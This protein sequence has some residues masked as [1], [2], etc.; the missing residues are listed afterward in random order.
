[1]AAAKRRAKAR[2]ATRRVRRKTPHGRPRVAAPNRHDAERR[3][4]ALAARLSSV[5]A[6][7]EPP[8]TPLRAALTDLLAA[9]GSDGAFA[10][11]LIEARRAVRGDKRAALALAWARE[12]LRLAIEE[13]IAREAKADRLRPS[14]PL[15]ALA[16]LVLVA[17][18]SLVHD[19]PG[20]A[21]DR[22]ETL[23]ALV[24]VMP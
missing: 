3:L 11:A 19:P 9:Y 22:V 6:E 2:R 21:G 24:G 8:T 15:D 13:V 12:Q 10:A 4:L 17:A 5:A 14:L 23:L 7:S 16:W 20:E 1:M 18:E